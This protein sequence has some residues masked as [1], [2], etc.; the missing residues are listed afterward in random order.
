[1][2]LGRR[3]GFLVKALLTI[4]IVGAALLPLSHHDVVC[5]LKSPTHCTTCLTSLSGEA[6]THA[7]LLDV[8]RMADAGRATTSERRSLRSADLSSHTG[9]APPALA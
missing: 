8:W 1:M 2:T 5:H 3:G 9:R 7:T 4:Y 6:T